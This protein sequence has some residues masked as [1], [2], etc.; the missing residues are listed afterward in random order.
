MT[1]IVCYATDICPGDFSVL[2]CGEVAG[3]EVETEG[4]KRRGEVGSFE[5]SC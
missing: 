2:K 4:E 1:K 5:A 3:D